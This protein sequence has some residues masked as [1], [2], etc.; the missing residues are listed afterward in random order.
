MHL[1]AHLLNAGDGGAAPDHG[2]VGDWSH[3]SA[4]AWTGI[5]HVMAFGQAL[6]QAARQRI[7]G[8]TPQL[9]HIAQP[10]YELL[11]VPW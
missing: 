11:T 8:L 2:T 3:A 4:V 6:P 1:A 5:W 10:L 7:L 9:M